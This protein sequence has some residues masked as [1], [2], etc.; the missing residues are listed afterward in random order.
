MILRHKSFYNLKI[1]CYN[2]V[3]KKTVTIFAILLAAGISVSVAGCGA[4]SKNV[5]ALSSNWYSVTSFKKFQPTFSEGNKIFSREEIK[6][7]VT[8]KKPETGN[9][10]YSV[11]YADGEYVTTFYAKKFDT[12]NLVAEE[13]KQAYSS[14]GEITAYY[15]K[16]ELTVP[17]VTFTFK[18]TG[19]TKKFEGDSVVTE[20]Y[21]LSVED[22]LRP[23]YSK[24]T[25]KSTTP[26]AYQASKPDK[27]YKEINREYQSFYS[28]DGSEVKTVVKNFETNGENS[29]IKTSLSD[30]SNTL[31][32]NSYLNI[33]IRAANLSAGT[34]LSQAFSLYSSASGVQNYVLAGS[35]VAL[36]DEEKSAIAAKLEKNGLYVP[37]FD[38]NGKEL[39]LNTVA[40]K[41]GYNGTL[42]GVSQTYWFAAVENKL[43]NKG[44]A[45]L[46]KLSTP[47]AYNQGTLD[48]TLDSIESTFWSE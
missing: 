2:G 30:A 21:F 17:S 27:A 7:K 31:F 18:A 24:Q 23:L 43:N 6:Y 29:E 22:Y 10:D 11:E 28:F 5:A 15:Y 48:Y 45:T 42:T 36:D 4:N 40:V 44:R 13:Y 35:S 25:V 3:M 20:S 32:D 39:G 37:K 12:E 19:E 38:D 14:A 16:T 34:E 9:P 8:H 41:V 33:A 46:L 26:A 1:I 47:V